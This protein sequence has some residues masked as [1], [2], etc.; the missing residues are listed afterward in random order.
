MSL[1]PAFKNLKNPILRK[2]VGK[3]ATLEKVAQMGDKDVVTF[4]NELR[5]K[6]GQPELTVPQNG[7]TVYID[8]DPDWING[9]PA[10]EIDGQA[11]LDQGEHPLGLINQLMHSL[12]SGQF[13]LLKT[14]FKPLPLIDEML[15]QNYRVHSRTDSE[16]ANLHL[17][18]I[19]KE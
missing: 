13:I 5:R 2:T 19:G 4:I 10:H 6:V 15:K 1:S 3:L 9:K 12:P 11:M 16:N 8:G 18:F 7:K 17:T 14:H